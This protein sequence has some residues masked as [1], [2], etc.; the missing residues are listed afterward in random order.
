MKLLSFLLSFFVLLPNLANAVDVAVDG[1]QRYFIVGDRPFQ[2]MKISNT[3]QTK[4]F[5]ISMAVEQY[6]ALE[7]GRLDLKVLEGSENHFMLA[8]KNFSLAPGKSRNVRLVSTRPHGDKERV[9]RVKFNPEI[10]RSNENDPN[11]RSIKMGTEVITTA[12]VLV[13]VSP[14]EIDF[15]VDFERDER[16]VTIKNTGNVSI[17]MRRRSNVCSEIS[18]EEVCVDLPG[19]RVRPGAEYYYE[20][21]PDL[22][23]RWLARVYDRFDKWLDIPAYEG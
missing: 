22:P 7:E 3:N 1:V 6:T 8:P 18:G 13:T 4:S 9:Y 17:F 16:G 12:G 10:K 2:G 19:Q 5:D 14:K 23:I 21:R 11:A 15:K 20:I